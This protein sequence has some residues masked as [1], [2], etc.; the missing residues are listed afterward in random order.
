MMLIIWMATVTRNSRPVI[1]A[2]FRSFFLFIVKF[3]KPY[4]DDAS[5]DAYKKANGAHGQQ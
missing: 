2:A 5:S 3:V 4:W 1:M